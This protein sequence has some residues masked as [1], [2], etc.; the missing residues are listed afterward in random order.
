MDVILRCIP[1]RGYYLGLETMGVQVSL[2][3]S[4]TILIRLTV[5]TNIGQCPRR[6]SE[7]QLVSVKHSKVE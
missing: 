1:G 4:Q 6:M 2:Q 3:N 5:I 7:R